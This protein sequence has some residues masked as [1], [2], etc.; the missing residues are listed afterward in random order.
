MS[1]FDGCMAFL[2]GFGSR[3]GVVHCLATAVMCMGVKHSRGSKCFSRTRYLG[4]ILRNR[5]VVCFDGGS[6]YEG[7]SIRRLGARDIG[8]EARICYLRILVSALSRDTAMTRSIEAMIMGRQRVAALHI[9][10]WPG[11]GKK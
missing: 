11:P 4:R 6:W 1:C 10:P 9:L 5:S 3:P 2:T 7:S 8:E